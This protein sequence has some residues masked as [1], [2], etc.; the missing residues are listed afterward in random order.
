MR[1]LPHL[2]LRRPKAKSRPL[3]ADGPLVLPSYLIQ[4]IL[5]ALLLPRMPV[6][7]DILA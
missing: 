7:A 1:G 6:I 2:G 3:G 5:P 4:A